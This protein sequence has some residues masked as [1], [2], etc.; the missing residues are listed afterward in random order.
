MT[1]NNLYRNDPDLANQDQAASNTGINNPYATQIHYSAKTKE[2][3]TVY[4]KSMKK[5]FSFFG[6]GSFLYA[7]FYTFCLYKNAS[8]ITYPFFVAG[9]LYY[10]FFSMQK[11]G[12]PCK[13][14]SIFYIVS[15]VLLGI[16][17]CIGGILR[18]MGKA[19]QSMAVYLFA[20]CA[21]RIAFISILFILQY[22]RMLR[23]LHDNF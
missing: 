22:R 13:K 8:G 6:I 16:S 18:G 15:I 7:I 10:F 14:D 11:L 21:V 17:N 2:E 23:Q 9:T 1:Q 5:H 4:T 12:V 19:K 20:W 3:D